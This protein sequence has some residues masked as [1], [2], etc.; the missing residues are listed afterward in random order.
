MLNIKLEMKSGAPPPG[1]GDSGAPVWEAG[2]RKIVGLISGTE[3][4]YG[5]VAAMLH[6]SGLPTEKVPGILNAPGIG[7]L[8]LETGP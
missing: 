6:P 5:F 3:E 4:G 2:T 7:N 1:P 8:I